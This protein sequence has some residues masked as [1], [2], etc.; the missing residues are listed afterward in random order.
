MV[1]P[2]TG[3]ATA[4]WSRLARVYDWQLPLERRAL[5]TLLSMLALSDAD[6]VLDVATG[7]G[8]VLRELARVPVPPSRVVGI[9][10][11]PPMLERARASLPPGFDLQCADATALPF[12]PASFDAVTCAYLLHLLSTPTRGRVLGELNRVLAPE[13]R[14]GVITVAP[15][16]SQL[17]A[18][19]SRPLRAAAERSTGALAGLRAFDPADELRAAGFK[20]EAKLRVGAPGYPSLCMR[21]VRR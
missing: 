7:T 3:D 6:R 20:V 17:G 18:L 11:S 19:V 16:R 4:V 21:A 15:A 9:D 5:R 13:G 12:E 8:A 2:E 14:L 1:S 10:R